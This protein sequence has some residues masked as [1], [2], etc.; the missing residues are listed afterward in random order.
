VQALLPLLQSLLAQVPAAGSGGRV[1][2]NY[3]ETGADIVMRAAGTPGTPERALITE[4]ARLHAV[5][6]VCWARG[7]DVPEPVC[8]HQSAAIRFTGTWRFRRMPSCRQH[9]RPKPPLCR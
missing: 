6:R 2:I 9:A 4:F 5:A 8:I 7:A 1:A 3:L